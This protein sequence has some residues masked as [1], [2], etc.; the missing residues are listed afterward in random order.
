MVIDEGKQSNFIE[1]FYLKEFAIVNSSNEKFDEF[2]IFDQ[3]LLKPSN[4]LEDID[5]PFKVRLLEY[6]DN[7]EPVPRLY[8]ADSTFKGMARTSH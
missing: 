3:A 4:I 2:I 5:L 8:V 7:V 6:F 1:N